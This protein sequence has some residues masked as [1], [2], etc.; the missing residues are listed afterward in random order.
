MNKDDRAYVLIDFENVQPKNLDLL[1]RGS[2]DVRVFV[3]QNQTRV[4]VNLAASMQ[5]LGQSAEY[6][7]I[8]GSGRNALDFH[9]AFYLGELASAHPQHEFYVVRRDRGFDP[10]I[11]HLTETRNVHARRVADI[12]EIPS[13]RIAAGSSKDDQVRAIVRNL[14]SRGRS[15]PRKV[16]TLKNTIRNLV[17]GQPS[18]EDL[19]ALVGELK[20]R[21]L[22][23][24]Q[25]NKVR[26]HLTR[27]SPAAG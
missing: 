8:S 14:R 16:S 7:F 17:A 21:R 6:V 3:G 13:L 11:R 1:A 5:K 18:D 22:I 9:I 2:F 10:L 19:E 4:P 26:Y 25:D 12:A 24:V 15:V 20:K 27:K 23:D